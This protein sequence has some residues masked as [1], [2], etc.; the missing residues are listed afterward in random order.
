LPDGKDILFEDGNEPADGISVTRPDGREARTL[1]RSGLDL[2][3]HAQGL[4]YVG[5]WIPEP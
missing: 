1:N 2:T 5:H 3:H 4:A